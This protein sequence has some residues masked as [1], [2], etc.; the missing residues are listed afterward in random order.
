M[1]D[2]TRMRLL[3]GGALLLAML[4]LGLMLGQL[5][6][7]RPGGKAP[8]QQANPV[9][10]VACGHQDR[11]TT[12]RLPLRCTK[13]RKSAV[14][15]AGLC[16]KCGT[17]TAWDLAREQELR[18]QPGLFVSRGPAYFFPACGACG[19]PTNAVGQEAGARPR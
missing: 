5:K 17:W 6:Q 3:M 14:H 12:E 8:A 11:Q 18:A 13:C 10:C 19:T 2:T 15:L 1:S 16:P 7:F 9:L 4:G